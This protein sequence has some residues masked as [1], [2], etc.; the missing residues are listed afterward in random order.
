MLA[1]SSGPP[2]KRAFK[3]CEWTMACFD[4][5]PARTASKAKTMRFVRV[6]QN[7]ILYPHSLYVYSWATLTMLHCALLFAIG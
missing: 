6:K 7:A 1:S 2:R 3:F 5:K 4:L